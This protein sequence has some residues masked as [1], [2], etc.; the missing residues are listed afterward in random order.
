M[1]NF[2]QVPENMETFTLPG[3]LYAAFDYKGL[4]TDD[5]IFQYIFGTWLPNSDYDL[6]D[7]PHFEVLGE[8]YRNNDPASEEEIWIPIK[9]KN[10]TTH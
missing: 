1:T 7:R 3:G 2:E 5:S 4:N 9:F 10:N 8:Q 6:D